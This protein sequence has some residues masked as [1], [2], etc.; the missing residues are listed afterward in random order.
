MA[1]LLWHESAGV[2]SCTNLPVLKIL[3]KTL[4]KKLG[5]KVTVQSETEGNGQNE[6]LSHMDRSDVKLFKISKKKI[7]ISH[8]YT[9]NEILKQKNFTGSGLEGTPKLLKASSRDYF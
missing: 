7:L 3:N 2:L 8:N 5:L 1:K 9:E 4:K 6:I